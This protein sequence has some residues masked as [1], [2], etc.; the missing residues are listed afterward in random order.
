MSFGFLGRFYH[1]KEIYSA[2]KNPE[3]ARDYV[4]KTYITWYFLS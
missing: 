2:Y 3:K 4:D 1:V